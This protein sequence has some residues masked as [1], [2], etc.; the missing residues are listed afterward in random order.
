MADGGDVAVRA[1]QG[2]RLALLAFLVLFAAVMA[3][4]WLRGEVIA[5]DRQEAALG[6][7]ATV[8]A[9]HPENRRFSDYRNVYVPEVSALLRAPRSGW[10]ATWDP[11]NELGRPL[12]HDAGFSPAYLPTRVLFA[13]SGD[14]RR[15][16]TLLSV[17]TALAA[18]LFAFGLARESRLAPAACLV[19]ATGLGLGPPVLYWLAF[20]MFHA[21]LAWACGCLYAVARLRRAPG[22]GAWTLLAF[23]SYSL[24]MT[25]YEQDIVLH[26]YLL[27]GYGA[28]ALV[29]AWRAQGLGAAAR[30]AAWCQSAVV[31]GLLAALPVYLDLW[32]HA[33]E[34]A[35]LALDAGFFLPN[36]PAA[37]TWAQAQKLVAGVFFQ[38]LFGNPASAG[39]AWGAGDMSL[40]PLWAALVA[41]AAVLRW[42]RA[43][44]WW[45]AVATCALF[46]FDHAAY[47]FAVDYLGLGL[48]FSNPLYT[49]L[50]PLAMLAAHGADA[51]V[52]GE[53]TARR[54]AL[55]QIAATALLAITAAWA[56][57]LAQAAGIAPRWGYIAL[58]AA[59]LAGVAS[60]LRQPRHAAGLLLLA[61]AVSTWAHGRQLLLTQSPQRIAGTS[62][63]VED[64]RRALPPGG[65]YAVVGD[66]DPLPPNLNATLGLRSVHTYNSL[67]SRRYQALVAA[68][69]GATAIHGRH[70]RTVA[71]RFDAPATQLAGIAV[72]VSPRPLRDAALAELPSATPGVHLYRVGT[73][74]GCCVRL[75][76]A[77]GPGRLLPLAGLAGADWEAET[78]RQ[79]AGDR[80]RIDVT[81]R[82]D[83]GV[84]VLARAF[85][86]QWRARGV[87][88]EGEHPLRTLAGDGIFLAVELPPGTRSV[89]LQFLPFA[90]LAWIP[91][92]FFLALA[93]WLAGAALA[94]RR[95]RSSRPAPRFEPAPPDPRP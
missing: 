77:A 16:L 5:P 74:R 11:Y 70:N 36:L 84:L 95:V 47:R 63:L 32:V 62:P 14:A 3:P 37:G 88:A 7:P 89:T 19:A 2:H 66:F 54:R 20:P 49:A 53:G 15:I 40:P 39:F 57:A 26:A 92:L 43:A 27:A 33:Q 35:R 82:R 44:G 34:S 79:D 12:Y 48:S 50:I 75:P 93:A 87:D 71:P 42:R 6:L 64:L 22:P 41:V 94:R 90:R 25:G 80:V 17:L 85:H 31:A 30:L 72:V 69:G 18:G 4:F 58:A 23:C 10:L 13:L 91:H 67:S 73:Y 52:A 24:L 55:A 59:I 1:T 83:A 60:A 38:D 56:L 45:I 81:P 65:R 68:L 76:G 51:L 28:V 8:D 21:V 78:V 9:G 46:T 29:Q 86:P 61:V